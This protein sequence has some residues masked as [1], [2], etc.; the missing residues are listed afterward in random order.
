MPKYVVQMGKEGSSETYQILDKTARQAVADE[1]TA[2]QQ[3]IGAGDAAVLAQIAPVFAAG[4]AYTAGQHVT[5]EGVV[6][7]LT[8]N[9][10]AG[11]TWA[12]TQKA[13]TNLGQETSD[14]NRAISI[15]QEVQY[16]IVESVNQAA[17]SYFPF[18]IVA[19]KTYRLTNNTSGEISATTR[20]TQAGSN[21]DSVGSVTA[22]EYIDFTAA[23]DAN[24]LRVYS[25]NAG[26]IR[27]EQ[28]DTEKYKVESEIESIQHYV[29]ATASTGTS[30]FPFVI[31]AGKTYR[32]TN[33]TTGEI[34]ATTRLL[35]SGSNVDSIGS[36][37]SGAYTD[38]TAAHDANY[39]R[40]YAETS[41]EIIFE[42][43][44]TS[45][46]TLNSR[47]DAVY[48]K[49]SI[50]VVASNTVYKALMLRAGETIVI[51]NTT[52]ST[53]NGRTRNTTG[54]S[55]ID[56]IGVIDP[57]QAVTFL[58]TQDAIYLGFYAAATGSVIVERGMMAKTWN[59]INNITDYIIDK[60]GSN[61][62]TSSTSLLEGLLYC[63]N[64]NISSIRVKPGTY[65]MVDEYEAKYGSDWD[66]DVG[67]YKGIPLGHGMR[68]IFDEG[69]NVVF[70]YT[71]G[72]SNIH[73]K[74]SLFNTEASDCY[75]EG[76]DLKCSNIRYGIHDDCSGAS[77]PYIHT[78]KN[79]IIEKTDNN[80]DWTSSYAI[81]GGF[82]A[83]ARVEID[84]G[85]FKCENTA[86]SEQN[87][88]IYYHNNAAGTGADAVVYIHGIYC[89]GP[90]G[91]VHSG[92]QQQSDES[93]AQM[94]VYG[95]RFN[96]A[97][98]QND[99]NAIVLKQWANTVESDT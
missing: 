80:S 89:Y 37:V 71:G 10:A 17:T 69:A 95:C 38:F 31:Q 45:V 79:C 56:T 21:I 66:T 20:E 9:H 28:L 84:G 30:Y 40:V 41:G 43:L 4:T 7:R 24:I 78:F 64:H 47:M 99:P 51:H 68:V 65:N 39:I 50:S 35:K 97:P 98:Q 82:G 86:A 36:L 25:V 67:D 49:D 58:I 27:F 18:R 13:A 74:M 52:S 60:N 88:T 32:L 14:L 94:F 16:A 70:N 42:Q 15:L 57:G 75:V 1:A 76:L 8:A 2:R 19:G 53:V 87:D 91:S 6:Y 63:Y 61:T 46:A 44:D 93:I 29:K 83:Y 55:N 26:K 3:A 5:Y 96:R 81:A 73:S 12:N 11:E 85:M 92:S 34:N 59:V 90:I 77:T 72:R 22:G 54:G 48:E 23:H 62:A 33:N